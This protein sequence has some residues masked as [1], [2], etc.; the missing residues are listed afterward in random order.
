MIFNAT[1][2]I[3]SKNHLGKLKLSFE[4]CQKFLYASNK[5]IN[6]SL[7]NKRPNT[8]KYYKKKQ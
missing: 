7:K 3:K 4:K 1:K 2:C 6:R 8:E 5:M